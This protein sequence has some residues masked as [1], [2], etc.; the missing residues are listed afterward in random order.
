MCEIYF[1]C[2]AAALAYQITLDYVLFRQTGQSLFRCLC[3]QCES[4]PFI[5]SKINSNLG[6]RAKGILFVWQIV[7][8]R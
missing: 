5:S 3:N 7:D 1:E 4:E 2:L 8:I 6:G